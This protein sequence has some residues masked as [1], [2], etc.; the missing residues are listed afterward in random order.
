[1]HMQKDIHILPKCAQFR[2]LCG[3]VSGWVGVE[4]TAISLLNIIYRP[5]FPRLGLHGPFYLHILRIKNLKHTY[6]G[7][8]FHIIIQHPRPL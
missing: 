2:D 3:W 4:P 8:R 1:M 6:I 7:N 5:P